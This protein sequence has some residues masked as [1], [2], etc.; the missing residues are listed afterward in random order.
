VRESRFVLG[1]VFRL[2]LGLLWG[3][4]WGPVFVAAGCSASLG[5]DDHQIVTND[6][7]ST[8]SGGSGMSGAGGG[9]AGTSGAAGAGVGGAGNRAGAGGGGGT[10]VT[11]LG[12]NL[13]ILFMID[14]SSSMT[15][16][17]EKLYAQLP[18]F[19]QVFEALPSPPSLHI[20]VVSSDMGAPG[21]VTA[22]IGCTPAGDQGEFQS[23]PR[24]DPNLGVDCTSTTLVAGAT[25]ISDVDNMPNYSD[26]NIADVF[27]CI[28]LLGDQGC[29]FE[30]QLA[31]ID[32]AL[33]ADDVQ[34]G[35]PTPPATNVG[36]LRPDAYLGIVLLTNEDDCSAPANTT[37]YSLNGMPQNLS[38]VDG[39]I[40][41]YRCNGGPRGGHF[42]RDLNP[43]SPTTGYATP[44]LDLPADATGTPPSLDLS[45]CEDN[46]SG[47]SALTPVTQFVND[48]K[49]LKTDPDNQIL[50]AAIAAPAT[51]YTVAWVPAQG[52]ASGTP[53]G[54]LWPQVEH[55]CGPA[56]GDD[57]N[58]EST[59]LA[60]DE[61]FGDPGVR[62]AQ[63]VSS[64]PNGV[65]ASICDA[66][67][68]TSM[69]AIATKLAALVAS[70]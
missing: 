63:F 51:P 70:Q 19:V 40:A 32:R 37:I 58:P 15:E 1:P 31:S 11:R 12:N 67:Y 66:S 33:G 18:T 10:V 43:D 47:S 56:G 20:A 44:P 35:V 27:K 55:S 4:L 52:A 25:F 8:S 9:Q 3:L 26:P 29:G 6:G 60:T 64:F 17:Q 59:Q 38:N 30:H 2:V 49:S 57:V 42:C 61:S 22:S 50:V 46:E 5:N 45:N 54:E 68:A 36:F 53:A 65:L 69:T 34:N 41:N 16:M 62:I 39:P 13:D 23:A 7:G 21:D 48:I 24:S 14:N 28:A